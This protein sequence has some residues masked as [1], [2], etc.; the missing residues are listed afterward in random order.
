MFKLRGSRR[1]CS[2]CGGLREKRIRFE[3]ERKRVWQWLGFEKISRFD[4]GNK[5]EKG[6]SN[7]GVRVISGGL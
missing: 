4:F 1:K 6:R 3:R 5:F 2:S 7:V